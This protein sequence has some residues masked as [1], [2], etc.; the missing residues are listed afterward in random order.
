MKAPSCGCGDAR[1]SRVYA[2]RNQTLRGRCGWC[3]FSFLF[4][5]DRSGWIGDGEDYIIAANSGKK[6]FGWTAFLGLGTIHEK[7][8]TTAVV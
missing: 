5:Y 4:L 3:C 8:Q 2:L 1:A 7:L 6:V